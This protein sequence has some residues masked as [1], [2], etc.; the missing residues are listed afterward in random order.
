[1]SIRAFISIDT[2]EVVRC[3]MLEVQS[4]LSQ[5]GADVR[6]E[7]KEKFHATIKFL[8][9]IGETLLAPVITT[10]EQSMKSF[11]AFEVTYAHLGCFPSSKRPRVIWFGCENRDGTLTR[12]KGTL[13]DALQIYG[14]EKENRPF[15]PHITIGRVKSLQGIKTL[16]PILESITFQPYS[17]P[18][19][20]I[21]LMKSVLKPHGSEYSVVQSFPLT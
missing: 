6:W 19:N 16:T 7:P 4:K 5:S 2:S 12:I 17:S 8:G 13:D 10:I 3:V 9:N 18:C 1:M 20:E 15:H 14:F 21:L 11:S